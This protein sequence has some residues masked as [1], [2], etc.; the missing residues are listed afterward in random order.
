[1][2]NLC[3]TIIFILSPSPF[4]CSTTYSSV[5]AYRFAADSSNINTSGSVIN[6]FAIENHK[7]IKVI[8]IK[9]GVIA[10]PIW[11]K[12]VDSN[13]EAIESCGDYEKEMIFLKNNALN[14]MEKGLDVKIAVEKIKEIA[15]KSNPH[16]SYTLGKD[17]CFA[18][19]M[20]YLPQDLINK[21]V[22]FGLKCRIK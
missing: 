5:A 16:S 2:F 3:A 4:S 20:S 13:S 7:N 22:K 17:A 11:K 8:S 6:A 19:L 9:P 15:Q 18:G 21:L 1:M 12:S 14:N 10:T